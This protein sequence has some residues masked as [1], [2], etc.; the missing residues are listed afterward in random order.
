MALLNFKCKQ[1]LQNPVHLRGRNV[2]TMITKTFQRKFNPKEYR[3]SNK[4]E[5]LLLTKTNE[6]VYCMPLVTV[7]CFR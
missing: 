3:Y 4:K 2:I 5:Q 7:N 1:T 6:I